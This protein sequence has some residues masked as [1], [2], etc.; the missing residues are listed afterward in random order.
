[1]AK[2]HLRKDKRIWGTEKAMLKRMNH[3]YGL[4]I[5]AKQIMFEPQTVKE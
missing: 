5:D 4:G 3:G 1:M 2:C